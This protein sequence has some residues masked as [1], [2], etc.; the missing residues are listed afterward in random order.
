MAMTIAGHC[1]S[2]Q[3]CF[4]LANVDSDIFCYGHYAAMPNRD[5]HLKHCVDF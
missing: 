4:G 3:T 1:Q 5:V 2:P